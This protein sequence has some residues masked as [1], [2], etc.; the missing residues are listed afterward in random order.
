MWKQ[1][2]K[3]YGLAILLPTCTLVGYI[4]GFLLDKGFG[5]RFFKLVFLLLGIAAGFIELIRELN[6]DQDDGGG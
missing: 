5:T 3:Y 2:G 4:I 1:F 6:K